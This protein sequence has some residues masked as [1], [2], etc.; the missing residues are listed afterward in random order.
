MPRSPATT[1][2]YDDVA[3]L[4][5]HNSRQGVGGDGKSVAT[6]EEVARVAQHIERIE[7]MGVC[8]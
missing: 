7:N 2:R 8:S 3:M 1:T 5:P 4:E 6:R